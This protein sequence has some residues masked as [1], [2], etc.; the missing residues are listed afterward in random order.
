V[1][2]RKF[3]TNCGHYPLKNPADYPMVVRG[4][5]RG[6]DYTLKYFVV[7]PDCVEKY[8]RHTLALVTEEEQTEWLMKN[9]Y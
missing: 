6:K 1:V 9:G 8:N 7:C 3:E 2:R 4:G 5:K